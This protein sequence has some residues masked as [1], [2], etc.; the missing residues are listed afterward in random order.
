MNLLQLRNLSVRYKT[1]EGRVLAIEDLSLNLGDK[2]TLGIVGESGCGK[3]TLGGAILGI[4]PKETKV[5]GKILFDGKDLV[6]LD[7]KTL[8]KIRGKEISMIFQDPM[9]SLNP[10]MRLKDHFIETIQTHLIDIEKEEAYNMAA[11]ALENV[12]ISA[13]RLEDY[14]FQ[15]SGGMR[16]RVMIALALVL[17]P[18][19]V[20][21]DE[22]TTSLDVIVQA[23][24]LELLKS[25]QTKFNT[26]MILITHDLGVVAETADNIGV[27][28]GGHL[29]EYS[30]K[31]S[32]YK[33][34]LHPYTRSLLES[35]PNTNLNDKSLRYIPGTPPSLMTPPPGCRFSERCPKALKVCSQ[36]TPPEVWTED[37]RMVKCWLYNSEVVQK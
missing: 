2:E 6:S 1:R 37:G 28:Y 22:P 23:Q 31:R 3:S 26:A 20:I 13:N 7:R 33:A 8:R 14:P 18:K 17:N 10:V 11:K 21:A 29:V 35:I 32:L 25:L 5:T 12:G 15:L 27:M 30:D 24:I 36:A 9:T 34:P 16:Q 4:L 19:I